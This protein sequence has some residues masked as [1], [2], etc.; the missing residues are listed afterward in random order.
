MTQSLVG[1]KIAFLLANG[2]NEPDLTAAQRSLQALGANTRIVSINTGLVN[3]WCGSEWGLSFAVDASLNESL[4]VDYDM[5]IVAGGQ[6][7]VEKLK[8]T[9]HTG[10]FIGGFLNAGKKVA[11]FGRALELLI[12]F[13]KLDGYT[14]SGYD[15]QKEGVSR[16][17]GKWLERSPVIHENLLSGVVQEDKRDAFMAVVMS[18]FTGS[19][20]KAGSDEPQDIVKAA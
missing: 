20:E 17:G 5:L 6:R 7:S 9:A 14:V 15:N 1:K 16:A 8:L 12:Y 4:A 10:R 2:F 11:V 3:G 19:A 13:D 18:H